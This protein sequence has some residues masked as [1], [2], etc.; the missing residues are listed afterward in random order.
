MKKILLVDDERWVRTALKWTIKKLA[1][2]LEI[3]H[4][5]GNGLEALDWIKQNDVD[6]VITDIQMPIMDGL[7]LANE[8]SKLNKKLDCFIISV[9]HE[10]QL[11]HQA[12]RSGVTDYLIK[13]IDEKELKECL[14]RWLFKRNKEETSR[15]IAQVLDETIPSSTIERVLQYI[16]KTPLD[17]ITLKAAAD[18][19]HIN[20]SYLSQLFKQQFNKKFVGYITEL[21]IEESKRL[22]QN[23]SLRMSEIAERVGYSDLAYFSNNFKRIT[24]SSPS[25]FRKSS[26]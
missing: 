21:R 15:K 19:V 9:H 3:I 5:C 8:L 7:S 11:A 24:G 2:P 20:P 1:L 16:E 18:H 12:L 13:P 25:E 26:D 6:L 23:T 4:E 14:E 22:L 10:F 17:Q